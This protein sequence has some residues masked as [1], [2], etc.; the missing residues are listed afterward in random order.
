[1]RVYV[2][3]YN[4]SLQDWEHIYEFKHATE[5]EIRACK[6][7]VVS[8]IKLQGADDRITVVVRVE[9]ELR[10]VEILGK[11]YYKAEQFLDEIIRPLFKLAFVAK[12]V[13]TIP[14]GTKC[15][16]TIASEHYTNTFAVVV[17]E[18]LKDA[19]VGARTKL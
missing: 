16:L 19:I 10:F 14:N 7:E 2:S 6:D 15:Y 18:E 13:A 12:G 9:H 3:V 11:E 1:M 5:T 8:L 4:I 17:N